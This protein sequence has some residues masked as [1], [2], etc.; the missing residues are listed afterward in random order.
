MVEITDEN[1]HEYFFDVRLHEPKKDQIMVCYSAMADFGAGAE[2]RQMIELLTKKDK[3]IAA[4][5]VMRKLLFAS[6]KD[7]VRVPKEMLE[8]LINGMSFKEVEKKKY[9]YKLEIFYYTNP[10]YV[11]ID[12]H[13]TSI[14]LIDVSKYFQDKDE[15]ES[16]K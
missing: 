14:S 2:K 8:D 11:P 12:P 7:S 15:I 13:W 5:N 10:E 6:E 3:A 16:L 1:F 9:R 4:S